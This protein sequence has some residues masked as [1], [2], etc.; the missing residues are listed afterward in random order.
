MQRVKLDQLHTIY[1]PENKPNQAQSEKNLKWA[2]IWQKV[3][4]IALLILATPP[5]VYAYMV[6][7]W[8]MAPLGSFLTTKL[9][10]EAHSHFQQKIQIAKKEVKIAKIFERIPA[11][12]INLEPSKNQNERVIQAHIEYETNVLQKAQQKYQLNQ[13][14]TPPF[15]AEEILKHE[16]NIHL[17]KQAIC[18]IFLRLCYLNLVQKKPTLHYK[19]EELI[20]LKTTDSVYLYRALQ[21]F[22]PEK[23]PFVVLKSGKQLSL[24]EVFSLAAQQDINFIIKNCSIPRSRTL[25]EPEACL[26]P[27]SKQVIASMV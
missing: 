15:A 23:S 27:H 19:F 1:S 22:F 7:V 18:E 21:K 8:W 6:G 10:S 16:N 17:M 13:S 25:Q 24:D 2:K 9:M 14:Q 4:V 3:S 5:L 12:L 11:P 20:P 26:R